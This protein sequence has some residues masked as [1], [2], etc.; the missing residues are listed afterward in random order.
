MDESST[1]TD[2]ANEN[3]EYESRPFVVEPV[4]NLPSDKAFGDSKSYVVVNTPS[5]Q[6]QVTV[7]TSTTR[8]RGPELARFANR[9]LAGELDREDEP[10]SD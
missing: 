8:N 10:F 2:F 4:A 6:E 5:S 3:Y 9:V 1:S 7:W